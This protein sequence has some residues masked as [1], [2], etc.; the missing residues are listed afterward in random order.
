MH[1]ALIAMIH[2]QIRQTARALSL[3]RVIVFFDWEIDKRTPAG[4]PRMNGYYGH[5]ANGREVIG[6]APDLSLGRLYGT[7]L[8][9]AAHAYLRHVALPD[10]EAAAIE[11][12]GIW[13]V[14][15]AR[16]APRSLTEFAN[17]LYRLETYHERNK[18]TYVFQ[19]GANAGRIIPSGDFMRMMNR[20][21]RGGATN[22]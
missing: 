20:A 9:E 4:K 6:L 1:K 13:A 19:N 17:W 10:V 12:G 18:N 11:L 5:D 14:S 21:G 3:C 7:L 2:P 15:I 16:R 22:Q 8:H